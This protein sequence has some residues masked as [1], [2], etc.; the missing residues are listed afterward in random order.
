MIPMSPTS[1]N[2]SDCGYG[3]FSGIC[4]V[5]FA[6]PKL[7][8]YNGR[9]VQP[10][11]LLPKE[12]SGTSC[13]SENLT[14]D[15]KH[16]RAAWQ[17]RT[18]THHN[19]RLRSTQEKVAA[20]SRGRRSSIVQRGALCRR[21]SIATDHDRRR[22]RARQRQRH[23]LQDHCR[24]S[25][26]FARPT[27]GRRGSSGCGRSARRALCP[28]STGRRADADDAAET[29]ERRLSQGRCATSMWASLE[30]SYNILA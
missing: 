24:S 1:R 19:L 5:L 11:R 6:P 16:V 26:R 17:S 8:R 18:R 7:G 10:H 29:Q 2:V 13:R 15:L 22:V 12:G 4:V 23:D 25:E 20:H 21:L 30:R 9:M 27:C 14:Q 28:S 3:F